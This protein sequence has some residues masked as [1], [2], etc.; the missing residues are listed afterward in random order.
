MQTSL[1]A[2][3]EKQSMFAALSKWFLIDLHCQE[4]VKSWPL[5]LDVSSSLVR[6]LAVSCRAY[7]LRVVKLQ[8]IPLRQ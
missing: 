4:T 8:V 6:S 7:N 2:L 1:G 3:E 5:L